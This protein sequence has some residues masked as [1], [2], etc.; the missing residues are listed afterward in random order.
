MPVLCSGVSGVLRQCAKPVHQQALGLLSHQWR[1]EGK[2]EEVKHLQ[3]LSAG[4]TVTCHTAVFSQSC[5]VLHRSPAGQ[6]EEKSTGG[7]V[8]DALISKAMTSSLW[9]TLR[10]M[11]C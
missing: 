3:V 1:E 8:Y 2:L 9:W 5:D 6:N 10:S 7:E 11:L 4:F